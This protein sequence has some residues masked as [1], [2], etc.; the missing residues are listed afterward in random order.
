MGR[1]GRGASGDT[2]QLPNIKNS[3]LDPELQ[4]LQLNL[5][6]GLNRRK[7]EKD[8]HQPQVEG[9]IESIELAYRAGARGLMQIMPGTGR[10]I[11]IRFQERW[12]GVKYLHDE[13]RNIRYGIWYLD[14]LQR[15]FPDNQLAALAVEEAP[16]NPARSSRD[17]AIELEE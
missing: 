5:L 1:R 13:E 6:Q 14:Y 15:E 8:Q 2:P 4:R 7:L 12:L 10:F 11:A 17:R 16:S 3:K 9:M